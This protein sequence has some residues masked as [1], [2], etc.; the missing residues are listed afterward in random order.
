[1][2]G[3]FWARTSLNLQGVSHLDFC[4]FCLSLMSKS[5][6]LQCQWYLSQPFYAKWPCASL[7]PHLLYM[8]IATGVISLDMDHH[9]SNS[10]PFCPDLSGLHVKI[11]QLT[12]LNGLHVSLFGLYLKHMV[13]S[14]FIE[15]KLV[16]SISSKWVITVINASAAVTLLDQW[17]EKIHT[18]SGIRT[19]DLCNAGAVL[20]QLSYQSHMR[21]VVRGLALYMWTLCLAQV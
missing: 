9:S 15:W 13:N 11:K 2:R 18:L 21:A 8:Y 3:N 20:S 5:F 17:P 6:M 19:N 14:V 16:L 4:L 12:L 7:L 10:S 1:M